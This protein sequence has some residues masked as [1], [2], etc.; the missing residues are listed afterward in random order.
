M[1]V[2]MNLTWSHFFC[3][4]SVWLSQSN[5]HSHSQ[6]DLPYWSWKRAGRIRGA[7][8]RTIPIIVFKPD[9]DPKIKSI[10]SIFIMKSGK[11]WGSPVQ[12][13]LFNLA[14]RYC[15]NKTAWSNAKLYIIQYLLGPR[16]IGNS[17]WILSQ[18]APVGS[19][20]TLD[21]IPYQLRHMHALP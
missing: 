12:P 10:Y 19:N 15:K 18:V 3:T 6:I 7:R 4:N 21:T 17:W 11:C 14:K 2:R 13:H 8:T 1:P 9:I 20:W 16:I 5:A